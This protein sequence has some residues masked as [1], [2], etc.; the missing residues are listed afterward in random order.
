MRELFFE[1]TNLLHDN[2]DGVV[3]EIV[4]HSE[5][6]LDVLVADAAQ[7]VN[8]RGDRLYQLVIAGTPR[9]NLHTAMPVTTA[10]EQ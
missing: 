4:T 3:V 8:V 2:A 10:M 1:G 7:G 5:K 9:V 6:Q